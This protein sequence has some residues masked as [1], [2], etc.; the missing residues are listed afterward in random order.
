MCGI[1]ILCQQAV[2]YTVPCFV[3]DPIR[4]REPLVLEGPLSSR[5]SAVFD[6]ENRN[7]H[8]YVHFTKHDSTVD[9]DNDL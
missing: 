7:D 8:C 3:R 9:L 5:S 6:C 4:Y 1:I 2:V